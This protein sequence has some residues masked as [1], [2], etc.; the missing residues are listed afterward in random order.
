HS[1]IKDQDKDLRWI[2]VDVLG[3]AFVHILDKLQAWQDLHSL[4]QDEDRGVR[5]RAADILGLVFVHIPDKSQAWQDL[6]C[7]TQDEDESMRWGALNSIGSVFVHVPD[8]SQAWQDLI[9]LTQDQDRD[10]LMHAF[11][12]LGRVSVIKATEA[13]DRDTLRKE[14][15]AAIDYFEKSSK[16]AHFNNPAKFCL[17]FY[18]SYFAITFQNSREGE[19]KKYLADA[20]EAVGE[21]KGKAELFEAVESLA[22]ALQELQ[23]LKNKS[24][25]ELADEL[26]IYNWYCNKA[27]EHMIVAEQ[28]APGAVKLMRKCNPF[29]EEKMQATI[30]EIQEKTRRICQITRGSGTEYEDPGTEIH[31]AAKALSTEDISKMQKCS[32]RIVSQLKKFCKMLPE[33]KKSSVCDVV[34][35]IARAAEFPEKLN[36]IELALLYLCPLLEEMISSNNEPFVDVVILTV[37]PEEYY[38]ICNQIS[39]L[40]PPSDLGSIPNLYAWKFGDVFSPKFNGIYKVAIGMIGRA[41]TT[42]S[43]LAAT[44]AIQ[45]WRP[46]Y[47]IFS[48]IAGGLPD[49]NKDDSRPQLGDVVIADVIFGYE[50]GKVDEKF[51]PRG[52]WTYKTDQGLLNSASA[53]IL[54]DDWR[55]HIKAKSPAKWAPIV[56]SGEIASGDKVIDDPTNDFFAQVLKSWPKVKAVEMEGAGVAGAIEQAQSLGI[57]V[58][59]MMIRGISDLPRD[60]GCDRGTKER[61]AWK[62]YASDTAAAFTVGWIAEGLPLPPSARNSASIE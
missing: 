20:K 25:L 35:E 11:H 55:Q 13:K 47:V 6:I 37:L 58:G 42:N 15:S 40:R 62:A 23:V 3:S 8:K 36:K 57:S 44:G 52:N 16:Y 59:F 24:V 51:M 43:A 7:L 39:V 10:V 29:L 22:R 28:S 32:A 27:A 45:L 53:Y 60:N 17:P 4:I 1:L 31:K 54:Q 56:I 9:R 50:Y 48:G 41:G 14:L 5:K 12:T 30:A 49:P 19:V 46:R 2:A 34:E 33:E 61:D 26:N 21:S 18:R 38:G